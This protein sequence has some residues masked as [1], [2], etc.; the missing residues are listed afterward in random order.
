MPKCPFGLRLE[1]LIRGKKKDFAAEIGI[2]AK[3][4]SNILSGRTPPSRLLIKRIADLFHINERWLE[5]GEGLMQGARVPIVGRTTG[6]SLAEAKPG[7]EDLV[8]ERIEALEGA[9]QVVRLDIAGLRVTIR[10]EPL[11]AK[12]E[13]T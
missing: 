1:S 7:D 3:Q 9:A 6:G 8:T 5:S 4:L 10:V 2:S 11:D 12:G 13:Q